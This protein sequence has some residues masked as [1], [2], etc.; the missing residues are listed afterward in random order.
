MKTTLFW[1]LFIALLVGLTGCREDEQKSQ[2]GSEQAVSE[3]EPVTL[4]GAGATFPYPLYSKWISEYHR[5][6]PD[7]RIN[8]QSIGSGGGIR[9]IVARTVDF[10]A[11]DAPMKPEEAKKASGKLLHIPTTLGAVAVTYNLDSVKQP[12]KLDAAVLSDIYLGTIEKWSDP[13]LA[14][15]N[16]GVTLPD[17]DIAVV[18]RSDGSGTTA[19]YTDYLAKVS[20]AFATEV[21]S[22]K[23][24]RWP[25]GLGAKGN[26]GVTGQ[27]KTTPGA[28]GYVELAYAIQNELPTAAIENQAGAFVRPTI[29]AITAAAAGIDLPDSLYVSI[30]NSPAKGA[31]PI[32]AFS[33]MLVYEDA[34]NARKG[35]ALAEFLRWALHDGQKYAKPLH[36]APLP[37]GVVGKVD[38]KLQSLHAGGKKLLS[39]S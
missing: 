7:V 16:E 5:Q 35:K 23:S 8:Y 20:K 18:Y 11:S 24:V 36:Y 39:G 28:I 1:S 25:T 38:E 12:L 22:G 14:G 4:N 2:G 30:T 27:I 17:E 26:E 34:K 6:H 37:A 21:G 13:R 10:G 9:Q 19:V 15:L 32:A 3:K 29:D 33:Y 31:Y